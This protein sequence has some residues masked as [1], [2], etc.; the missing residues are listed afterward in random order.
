ALGGTVD[1]VNALRMRT[2]EGFPNF[3]EVDDATNFEEIQRG[4][5]AEEDPWVYMHRGLGIPGRIKTDE[6]GII[7]APAT[8]EVF[9]RETYAYWKQLM[10]APAK[11][12][13]RREV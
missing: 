6:N 12:E 3:G 13:I 11:R 2:M 10:A 9:M 4:L 8:D 5:A 1:D 7:T